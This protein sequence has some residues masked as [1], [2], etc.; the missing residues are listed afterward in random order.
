M[1]LFGGVEL[2]GTNVDCVVASDPDHVSA[3]VRIQ[4]TDPHDTLGAVVQFFKENMA[5]EDGNLAAIGVACFGPLNLDPQSPHFGRIADTPKPGW[6]NV[7]V[8]DMIQDG[9]GL[10]AVIDTDVNGAALGEAKWGVAQGLDNFVYLTIGTGIGGG[11]LVNGR[12]MHGLVH[13]EMGHMR[14]PHDLEADPFPGVCPYHGDCWEGLANGPAIEA[15]W[16]APG[17]DL[18]VDH[19]AW[20]LEAHYI[21]LA[22]HNLICTLSP[23]RIILGGGVSQQMH[24][25]P[26]IRQKVRKSLAGYVRS[27]AIL[28]DI[29]S[30]IVP[31]GLG[32]RAGRL[33]AV[34]MAMGFG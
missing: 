18:P 15:R 6:S 12:P 33:G 3:Q 7:R 5:P 4:T 13:P 23:A 1:Q 27:A 34:A 22:L 17:Q 29:D 9:V 2:G 25:F 30:F 19:P 8:L 31:P 16:G 14:L 28:D 32:D 10:P 20:E 26:L 21:A 24:I 11:G